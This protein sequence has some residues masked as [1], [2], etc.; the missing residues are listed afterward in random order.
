MYVGRGA[1]TTIGKYECSDESEESVAD[2]QTHIDLEIECEVAVCLI[3]V[4]A[5]RVR[6]PV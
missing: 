1:D 3:D 4:T 5:R 6:N 2:S